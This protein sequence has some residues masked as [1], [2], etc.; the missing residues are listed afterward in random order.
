MLH[1]LEASNQKNEAAATVAATARS[2]A[3]QTIPPAVN[4]TK[5]NEEN[6]SCSPNEQSTANREVE[7]KSTTGKR[8][9]KP[10]ESVDDGEVGGFKEIFNDIFQVLSRAKE[11]KVDDGVA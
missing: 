9:P 1:E 2:V 5:S 11:T 10:G 3:T 8:F 7:E 6:N 4:W